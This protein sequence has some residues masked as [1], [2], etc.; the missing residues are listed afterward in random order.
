M[1]L[2]IEQRRCEAPYRQRRVDVLVTLLRD[3]ASFIVRDEGAGFAVD[4]IPDPTLPE[5]LDRLGG[6]GLF[7]IRSFMDHVRHNA[8]GNEITMTIRR[9]AMAEPAAEPVATTSWG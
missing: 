3:E 4:Q 1:R 5:N 9:Q 2:L 7:L 8:S 6:R